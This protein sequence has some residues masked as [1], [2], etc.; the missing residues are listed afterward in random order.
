MS[1]GALA[2]TSASI[3]TRRQTAVYNGV[4]AERQ[5][6]SSGRSAGRSCITVLG[7]RDG[8]PLTDL[9]APIRGTVARSSLTPVRPEVHHLHCR[10][11]TPDHRGAVASP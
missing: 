3:V 10:L 4:Q 1:N 11:A 5:L 9:D 6:P 2:L 8:C 7:Y